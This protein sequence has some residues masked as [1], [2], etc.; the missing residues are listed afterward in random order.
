MNNK[1]LLRLKVFGTTIGTMVFMLM[2]SS[3]RS[4]VFHELKTTW[5]FLQRVFPPSLVWIAV[6]FLSLFLLK[7]MLEKE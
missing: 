6:I 2:P 3:F 1:E 5:M 7:E 4:A